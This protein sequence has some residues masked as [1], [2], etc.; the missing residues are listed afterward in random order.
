MTALD[1]M[2][3]PTAR[4]G[5]TEQDLVGTLFGAAAFQALNAGCELGLFELLHERPGV[6]TADVRAALG[7]A[8]RSADVLLEAA[9]ALRL[10]VTD[11]GT[12]RN[13]ELVDGMIEQGSWE[14]IRDLV[15]FEANIV[16]PAQADT[17][18]SLC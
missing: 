3:A 6:S 9:A 13:A 11:G 4:A 10:T 12:H 1:P 14:I 17:V 16:Y 15:A 8:E 18:E 5:L 2:P 7:L